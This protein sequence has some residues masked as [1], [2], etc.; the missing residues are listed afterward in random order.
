MNFAMT[1]ESDVVCIFS[2]KKD[3]VSCPRT[4][5]HIR[6]RLLDVISGHREPPYNRPTL[7]TCSSVCGSRWSDGL[8]ICLSMQ[9]VV[10]S[11]PIPASANSPIFLSGYLLC[12]S[13]LIV[14]WGVVV[15]IRFLLYCT[16]SIPH[17]LVDL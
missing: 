14:T 8:G 2:R 1:K 13:C 3:H 5:K 9:K 17:I 6:D 4:S 15:G 12:V 11:I 10:G 16:Y 7:S